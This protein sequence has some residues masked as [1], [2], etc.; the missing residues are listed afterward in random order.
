MILIF[1]GSGNKL[2]VT[3]LWNRQTADLSKFE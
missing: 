2:K 1:F 3:S